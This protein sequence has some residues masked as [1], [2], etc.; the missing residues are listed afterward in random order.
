LEYSARWGARWLDY[1]VTG[2]LLD[3]LADTQPVEQDNQILSLNIQKWL[4]NWWQEISATIPGAFSIEIDELQVFSQ[5]QEL[6]HTSRFSSS[7][8]QSVLD[9]LDTFRQHISTAYDGPHAA[10][11]RQA[12]DKGHISLLDQLR[13]MSMQII[14]QNEYSQSEMAEPYQRLFFL[15][16]RARHFVSL[17]FQEARGAIPRAIRQL[18]VLNEFASI[19]RAVEQHPHSIQTYQE[20][21]E[22]QAQTASITLGKKRKTWRLPLVGE[23]LRST[24]ISLF[25]VIMLG[26]SLLVGIQRQSLL[27]NLYGMPA[28]SSQHLAAHHEIVL[29]ILRSLLLLILVC[30]EWLYLSQ[31][32]RSLQSEYQ[33]IR[34]ELCSTVQTHMNSI[35]L[36]IAARVAL[37]LLQWADLYTPG[38]RSCP[39]EQRLRELE[40][41]MRNMRIQATYQQK[42]AE[43]RLRPARDAKSRRSNQAT[44][45]PDLHNRREIIA[46]QQ[47]EDAFLQSCKELQG[48]T[49][50]VNLLAEMLLRCLGTE[51]HVPL[52][53]DMLNQQRWIEEK[54]DETRFQAINT[55]LVAILLTFSRGGSDITDILPLLQ[56]YVTL[57]ELYLEESTV[58]GSEAIDLQAIVREVML[59]QAQERSLE[60]SLSVL[61]NLP[62]TS[63]LASWVCHQHQSIPQLARIFAAQDILEHTAE[64]VMQ[65]SLV[66][67]TLRKQ[68]MLIG[69]PDEIS[70]E[71]FHYLFV[72]PGRVRKEFISS[73]DPFHGTQVRL[74]VFPDREKLVYMHIHQVRQLLPSAPADTQREP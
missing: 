60:A 11:L 43:L 19:I 31:R 13:C 49:A 26:V 5:L 3:S 51:R 54:N 6:M 55:L 18:S 39:Y 10:T 7:A 71:D 69:Y 70:G 65:P 4:N 52:L 53:E 1:G 47:I 30:S 61:R 17:H 35:G 25:V 2:K 9:S 33:R 34:A 67:D 24:A 68:G 32:N 8:A 41:A 66:V 74:E 62:A 50:S 16:D 27:S 23:V 28:F 12:L 59:E 38:E 14:N 58:P 64:L 15:Y 48:N 63:V 36:V 44:A 22:Q 40:R 56:Q 29:W 73:I 20:Q 42:Q 46:W 45:I 72:G 21:F 57:K 37:A